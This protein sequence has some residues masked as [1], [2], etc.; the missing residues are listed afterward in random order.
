[1]VM[2]HTKVY[3]TIWQ[4]IPYSLDMMDQ[5]DNKG[6]RI[7]DLVL[8]PETD[9]QN[10]TTEMVLNVNRLSVVEDNGQEHFINKFKGNEALNLKGLH[11]GLFLKTKEVLD[12]NPGCYQ[13]FRFYL[14]N[15]G[16]YF[17]H[18]DRSLEAITGYSYV[19]FKIQNRLVLKGNESKQVI[20][21][22]DFKP[23]SIGSYFR[24]F[25]NRFKKYKVVKYKLVS[26]FGQ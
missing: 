26:S 3:P 7:E 24:T 13:S 22:F 21:R 10:T 18:S 11:T 12:L 16:N 14:E 6:N 19:E 9:I 23:Y 5:W 1:M 8:V 2:K 15:K 20:L 25:L 4:S 17:F